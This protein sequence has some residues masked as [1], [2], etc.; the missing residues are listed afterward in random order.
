MEDPRS[1]SPGSNMPTY[2]WLLANTLDVSV[3][4]AK[5]KV[6]RLLGVPFAPLSAQQIFDQVDEQAKGIAKD[7]RSAGAYVVP[8]REIV[9][10]IAY[11]QTLGHSVPVAPKAAAR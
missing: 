11:L 9:A 5:I 8:D 10:L 6:Q 2:P 4:P 1:I 7:L 3:L